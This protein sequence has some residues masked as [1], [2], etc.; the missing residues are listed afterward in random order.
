MTARSTG[1]A[2]S[3]IEGALVEVQV[4][5]QEGLP[6]VD[7]T[8]LPAA[9]V[10]EA[11]HRVRSAFRAA[12]YEWPRERLVV[13][14]SPADS[15]KSGTAYDLPV[16]VSVLL[17]SGQLPADAVRGAVFYGELA[18]DGTV[19]PVRGAVNAALAVR[20]AGRSRLYTAREVA[21][22]AAAV[23]EVE[24]RAISSLVELVEG[25]HGRRALARSRPDRPKD[26]GNAGVD[27][28]HLR[29]QHRGR[30][31]LEVAAAGGHNL[32]MVGP[33]GCGKTLLARA[34]PGI[35]P[36]M[37]L[38]E[39]LE[40]TRIHSVSGLGRLGQGLVTARPFR[41]PHATASYAA[42]VG[43]GN[44]PCPGEVSLA[45][46]GVLFLDETPEF[47]RQAL[48]ALRAP[49]EDRCVTIARSGTQARFPASFSLLC[50][51][52]PCPCGYRDDPARP[53]RCTPSQ[54]DRY[55]RRISGPLLDRMDMHVE[56]SSVP[57]DAMAAA[58]DGEATAAVRER[59]VAARERQQARREGGCRVSTNAELSFEDLERY[60]KLGTREVE[61]L[62]K[63]SQAARL[64]ARSWHRVIRVARTIADLEATPDIDRRALAEALTY[65]LLD[66]GPGGSTSLQENPNPHRDRQAA[67]PGA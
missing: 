62:A 31:A 27:L 67:G 28:R 51:L 25:L 58:P 35:L 61:F 6:G 24:V 59:V 40:V 45:H 43:G 38:S 5:R 13:N 15:R 57:T 39:Q 60:A 52:N 47:N 9:S 10:R 22:E 34:M 37:S 33:P 50:A 66:R 18:L 4:D 23:P 44:P 41:A 19:Q 21:G 16:A 64:T 12:A 11:R 53:C 3:G 29:G 56:L 63:A 65:R 8:G 42:L 36:P 1:V 46:R 30:R 2:L 26:Q 55:R 7:I 54:V 20:D 14:L 17:L 49:L 48:E 32:L